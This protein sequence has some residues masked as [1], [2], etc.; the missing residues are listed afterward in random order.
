MTQRPVPHSGPRA[1]ESRPLGRVHGRAVFG[2]RRASLRLTAAVCDVGRGERR[3]TRVH[4]G[5][6]T[7]R[8]A[9]RK[10]WSEPPKSPRPMGRWGSPFNYTAPS[11]MDR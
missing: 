11:V 1:A 9:V 5:G 7:R 10:G 6:G 8:N 4:R 3:S 2:Q